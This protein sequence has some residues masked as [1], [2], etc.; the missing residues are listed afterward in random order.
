M[1]G[2][3]VV[4]YDKM[5]LTRWPDDYT[6]ESGTHSLT[7][8]WSDIP[9]S[10]YVDRDDERVEILRSPRRRAHARA[11]DDADRDHHDGDQD[12]AA[13]AHRMY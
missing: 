11:R 1:T 3:T 6:D 4:E 5:E 13:I 9:L 8:I 7:S 10:L 2:C 12:P